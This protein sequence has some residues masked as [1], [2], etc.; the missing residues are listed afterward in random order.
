MINGFR[1]WARPRGSDAVR[2]S[3]I[4]TK[5]GVLVAATPNTGIFLQ[6]PE[7]GEPPLHFDHFNGIEAERMLALTEDHEG[8]SLGR[9]GWVGLD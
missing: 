1:I 7:T 2:A 6:F 9:H 5:N 8:E 4:E 3:L